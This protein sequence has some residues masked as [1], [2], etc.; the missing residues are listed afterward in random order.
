M[1]LRSPRGNG[2]ARSSS[3]VAVPVASPSAAW[4]LPTTAR[5][6]VVVLDGMPSPRRVTIPVTVWPS[7][8]TLVLWWVVAY[9]GI[10]GARWSARVMRG[11]S[12]R[13]ARV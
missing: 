6:H 12:S 8:W 7:V 11:E 3:Y 9:L 5:L 2:S 13:V 4:P 1:P 10:V